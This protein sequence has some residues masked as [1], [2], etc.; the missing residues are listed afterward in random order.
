[1]PDLTPEPFRVCAPYAD[2]LND[3]LYCDCPPCRWHQFV[4][5][6]RTG[7]GERC[8]RCGGETVVSIIAT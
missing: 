1:M 7:P 4:D 3:P 2:W 8:P 6:G 5:G